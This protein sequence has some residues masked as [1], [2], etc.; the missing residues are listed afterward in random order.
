[1]LLIV[2]KDQDGNLSIA[3]TKPSFPCFLLVG[4]EISYYKEGNKDCFEI[5]TIFDDSSLEETLLFLDSD[6]TRNLIVPPDRQ[7]IIC[8]VITKKMFSRDLKS[9][10][11]SCSRE[12]ESQIYINIKKIFLSSNGYKIEQYDICTNSPLTLFEKT[13]SL[14][15]YS[16]IVKESIAKI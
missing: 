2:Q 7:I 14:S 11:N 6:S 1:M 5:T 16:N 15:K 12:T 4:E 9:I 13:D 10:F 3:D 8:T